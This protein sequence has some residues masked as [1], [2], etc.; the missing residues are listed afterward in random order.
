[1]VTENVGGI[2]GTLELN[3]KQYF[4]TLNKADKQSK[5]FEVGQKKTSNRILK[6]WQR[7]F[8][9]LATVGSVVFGFKAI[10]KE[11]MKVDSALAEISTLGDIATQTLDD[12]KKEANKL[13][14]EFK[15]TPVKFLTAAYDAISAGFE[16]GSEAMQVTRES[17]KLAKA[18]L[19]DAAVAVDVVTTALKAYGKGADEAGRV[20][21]ILFTTV[22]K[23]KVRLG[24][25]AASLGKAI[26][27]S[28][29]LGIRLEEVSAFIA[30]MTTGG[31]KAAEAVTALKGA[32]L[33]F[34]EGAGKFR[35]AGIDILKVI[36]EEGLLG[37][38]RALEKLTGGNIE[39]VK[40]FIPNQEALQGILALT[41][42]QLDN[43]VKNLKAAEEGIGVVD[44][45]VKK[46]LKTQKAGVEG[47]GAALSEFAAALSGE[48]EDD[49]TSAT[50]LLTTLLNKMTDVI[51]AR[52]ELRRQKDVDLRFQEALSIEPGGPEGRGEDQDDTEFLKKLA[53]AQA[54][55]RVNAE[56]KSNQMIQEQRIV[57]EKNAFESAARLAEKRRFKN[58]EGLLKERD[59]LAKINKEKD[60]EL[61]DQLSIEEEAIGKS[62]DRRAEFRAKTLQKNADVRRGLEIQSINERIKAEKKASEETAKIEKA[63]HE[64]TVRLLDLQT[65]FIKREREERK[66]LLIS[67]ALDA[68]DQEQQMLAASEQLTATFIESTTL[69]LNDWKTNMLLL[70]SDMIE[71]F[72]ESFISNFTEI[73]TFMA[74]TIA[75]PMIDA[76]QRVEKLRQGFKSLGKEMLKTAINFVARW[77]AGNLILLA[78]SKAAQTAQAAAAI[79]HGRIIAESYREAAL[80]TSLA[81]FG[82]NAIPASV[83]ILKTSGVLA[84]AGVLPGF[85][86]GGLVQADQV[87]R[88]HKNEMVLSVDDRTEIKGTLSELSSL[89]KAGIPVRMSFSATDELG[90]AIMGTINDEVEHNEGRLSASEVFER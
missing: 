33:A 61:D 8:L 68:F 48:F 23:G 16:A 6:S 44:T 40:E 54:E 69:A 43:Y 67:A 1:M 52:N 50:S 84:A 57:D 15:D 83:G 19:T 25:L 11:G 45:A 60:A 79:A 18:G 88:L 14:R 72:R 56:K 7:S 28:A 42:T 24:E 27:I 51:N 87:A 59:D 41:G 38:L 3:G 47:L 82:A 21:D 89:I 37:A 81:S 74:T 63:R 90:R 32:E 39:K 17:A 78:Q 26:P 20:A 75:D 29:K 64:L 35:K 58:L 49:V 86:E 46:Q 65:E 80:F 36:S 62:L 70:R 34:V 13:S 77:I 9:G 73:G 10:V 53:E 30:T 85:Q 71:S 55:D 4:L 31:F 5:K 76:E 2:F 22:Q 66:E 12:M